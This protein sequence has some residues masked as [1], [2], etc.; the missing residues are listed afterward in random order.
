[1]FF[2]GKGENKLDMQKRS[3]HMPDGSMISEDIF[4]IL[5]KKWSLPVIK[6]LAKNETLRFNQLKNNFQKI[7]PSTLSS[8]LKELEKH[9]I[10]QKKT[11]DGYFLTVLYFLTD[12][13]KSLH[14]IS[15]MI[16]TIHP[17]SDLSYLTKENKP[18]KISIIQ[19]FVKNEF[20][21]LQNK[22]RQHLIPL[23]TLAS[24]GAG[25]CSL[26]GIEHLQH[27]SQIS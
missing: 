5:G 2:F 11:D 10:V 23:A 7:T 20:A 16:E 24:I 13:G 21:T 4:R 26:H 12:Y 9:G 18:E 25:I 22:I 1:M 15:I 17:N 27:I 6:K 3:D 8:I 19:N 14:A